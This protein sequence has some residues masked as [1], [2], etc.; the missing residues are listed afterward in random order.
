[1]A[2]CWLAGTTQGAKIKECT[3]VISHEKRQK[4]GGFCPFIPN[5]SGCTCSPG[6][7]SSAGPGWCY[8]SHRVFHYQVFTTLPYTNRLDLNRQRNVLHHFDPWNN[9]ISKMWFLCN[10][11]KTQ[12]KW[13]SLGFVKLPEYHGNSIKIINFWA[14]HIFYATDAM[15]KKMLST[16][17]KAIKE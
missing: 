13:H 8:V 15:W 14:S 12:S 11:N 7:P 4:N 6:T 1:M 9:L 10:H 17:W 3:A 2:F 16:Y 5:N